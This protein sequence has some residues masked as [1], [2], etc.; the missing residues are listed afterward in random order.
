M[1]PAALPRVVAVGATNAGGEV[2][3]WSPESNN[4]PW[5]NV[6]ATGRDVTSTY[7]DGDAELPKETR[8]SEPATGTDTETK[9]FDGY[10]VWS[11]TSFAAAKVSGA[12]AAATDHGRVSAATALRE[13]LARHRRDD[14][15][16]WIP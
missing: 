15:T 13:F 10:A 11:G 16:A 12:V 6:L 14:G 9:K 7:I 2:A 5:V 4:W 3:A 8:K 1:W